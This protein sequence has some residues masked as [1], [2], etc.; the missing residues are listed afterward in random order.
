MKAEIQKPELKKVFSQLDD[1]LKH[2]LLDLKVL[3]LSLFILQTAKDKCEVEYLSKT[4][5]ASCADAA[6]ISVSESAIKTALARG[7]NKIA[8]KSIAGKMCWKIM[9]PGKKAIIELLDQGN[10]SLVYIDGSKPRTDRRN[11]LKILQSLNS[12]IYICDPY[13]GIKSL[14]VLENVNK[15]VSV[16]FLSKHL[17]GSPHFAGHLADFKKEHPNTNFRIYPQSDI[18]DRY[19]LTDGQLLIVGH[20]LK[21]MGG[22]ES[23]VVSINRDLAPDLHSQIKNSFSSKWS[24]STAI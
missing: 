10:I 15:S 13:F 11:F 2:C 6:E 4:E 18:H 17:D 23:F 1:G 16:S 22:K 24:R 14:D 3:D 7:G 5:I 12:P 21:D 19:I 8:K 20:G 9:L